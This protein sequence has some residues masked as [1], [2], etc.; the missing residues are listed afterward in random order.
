MKLY[1]WQEQA[2]NSDNDY[3]LWCAEAGTGKSFAANLWL[4]QQDRNRNPVILCPKQ[5]TK[6]W[7]E[8]RPNAHVATKQSILRHHLP[9][10][11]SAIIVDEADEFGSPLFVGAKRS[12]C[13]EILYNYIKKH[14]NAHVLLLTATPVRSSPWNIHT[15]LTYIRRY[16]DWKAYREKYFMLDH[17][18]Y[19]TRPAWFPRKGWQ[20]MM[21]PIIDK[22]AVLALMKDM[23]GELPPETYEVIKLPAP[24][25]EKNEEWEASKQF[26]EDH[27]LE[28]REKDSTIKD[29][30][31]GY[32]KVVIVCQYREQIDALRESLSK[33]RTTFVLDGRTG[34]AHEVIAAAEAHPEC[35]FI[36]QASVGAGFD[37]HSF[38]CMIFAS[39]GYSVRNYVQ[40]KARIRRIESLK[41]VIYYFLQA[42]RCD[43]MI[44]NSIMEGRD[45]VPSEYMNY[46]I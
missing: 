20:Q 29:V 19:M 25:Y 30:S 5:I 21:Q 28:Q 39:Q 2:L 43:R 10:N 3:A 40:M 1:A 7:S 14:P 16:E 42:G 32:R 46:D 17:P 37:L 27:L 9:E 33:E 26:V 8:R 41:P 18:R 11:P 34:D 13:A 4:D 38:A 35:Y 15:L 44:Y 6:N 23:V 31:K 24:N 12:K 45:F 22:N 36:I